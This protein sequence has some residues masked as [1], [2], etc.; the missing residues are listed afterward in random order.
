MPQ[1]SR[2]TLLSSSA[3]LMASAP[4][5]G[6]APGTYRDPA[7][8]VAS[9]VAD[10]LARMTL[11]EKVAQV[12]CLWEG[13]TALQEP[14][15]TFSRGKARAVIP[16]GIGQIARPS[17]YRGYPRWENQPFR[18]IENA[19]EWANALQRY[20][21]EDTRLGIPALMHEELA[22]GLLAGDATIFP[23]PPALAS[24]WDRDLVEQVFTVAAGEA[25]SRG[26]TVALTPVVD[27]IRDPRYGRNEEF[28]SEDPFLV[29]EIGLAAVRG[30]QGR[31]RPLRPDRVFATL[32]HFVHAVPQGGL[33]IAPADVGER[34]LRET[35]LVPFA[36]IIREGDPAIVMPSY[37]EIGGVPSHSN[38]YLL[39]ETG[40]ERL[41]FRGLYMS[42]YEGVANLEAQH[43]VA[44]SRAAAAKLALAAG[45]QADLPEGAS[46]AELARLV[47]NGA[48][49]VSVLDA[50]VAQILHLKFEAGLFE[51][52][53]SDARRARRAAITPA[54]SELAKQAA[55][56]A[57]TLLKNDGAVPISPRAG[58]KLAVVGPNAAE[59]LF[60]GYSGGNDKAVGV[61]EGIRRS[62]P[63]G[64]E[65][66]HAGGVWIT[67]PDET[68][69]HRS[70]SRTGPVAAADNARR[71]EEAVNLARASDLIV[72][73]V[74][75]VP[76]ITR[77]AVHIA[78]PGDRSTLGLWGDQDKLVE[79]MAALGK[80]IVTLVLCGRPLAVPRLADVSN[81]LFW[82]WYLG[83][84]GGPA[85]AD[86]LFGRSE[87]GGRLPVSLPRAVGELPVFY[88]RHPSADLNQYIEG[89]RKPLF[90]FGHG[91]GYTEIAIEA[92]RLEQARIATSQTA[93][94]LVDVVNL[95]ERRGDAV[96]QIYLRDHVSSVPRPILELKAFQRVTLSPGERRT[97]Q[98]TLGQEALGLWDARMQ[99]NVEP[100]EFTIF[101]GRSSVDLKSASLTV[102][103]DASGAG[104]PE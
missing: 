15:G 14:D 60:G 33:N 21:V 34:A 53:Y 30:L 83:Q 76:A 46:F 39:Q 35:F 81:A 74:G 40:R 85:F 44:A 31:K 91:L 4:A 84:E 9:R 11:E 6:K 26:A 23:I 64:V 86:I 100:G 2:R 56:K 94:V 68:G 102:Y 96:V 69:R 57:L 95:G 12:R 50:A 59:P 77:E 104:A 58:M 90:P 32:K 42:D 72:L 88:N 7:A 8:S 10:L 98:F 73:V 99:W 20:L 97:L 37:N 28:F 63:K 22:H 78:L 16:D 29:G 51:H 80:P 38:R 49:P 65:V 79:A 70:Y 75:D 61:L 3:L 66:A 54:S 93:H 45:V 87:P 52:P 43:H 48:V 62:V 103:A 55:I 25:R 82:G 92:P 19:V 47:R 17:D 27:L 1:M 41:G 18:T 24:S 5:L 13:K 36:R 89:V 67:P 101:A 71:I